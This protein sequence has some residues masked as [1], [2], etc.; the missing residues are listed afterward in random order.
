MRPNSEGTSAGARR[1]RRPPPLR[2]AKLCCAPHRRRLAAKNPRQCT[3]PM[4][5]LHVR[6]SRR[7]RIARAD[8]CVG[9]SLTARSKRGSWA[10]WATPLQSSHALLASFSR[11]PALVPPD[12]DRQPQLCLVANA[13]TQ[14]SQRARR[15]LLTELVKTHL[16]GQQSMKAALATIS[17]VRH[18]LGRRVLFSCC[19]S[20]CDDG[21][22]ECDSLKATASVILDIIALLS[23]AQVP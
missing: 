1:L 15:H 18:S 6:A 9:R 2:H 12:L 22:R 19:W 8:R 20:R 23:A 3:T 5:T 14:A 13:P 4:C 10:S 21:A 7:G 11:Q 16:P 17:E